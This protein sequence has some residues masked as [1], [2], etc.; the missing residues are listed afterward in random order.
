[1]SDEER[2]N[3]P[4]DEFPRFHSVSFA[5]EPKETSY[6]SI[7]NNTYEDEDDER[8]YLYARQSRRMRSRPRM[9]SVFHMVD[10]KFAGGI[11]NRANYMTRCF[12]TAWEINA[13]DIPSLKLLLWNG[14]SSQS[15][16]WQAVIGLILQWLLPLLPII[17]LPNYMHNL[18]IF[19][20][21]A[22]VLF[23]FEF[24]TLVW[25]SYV[26]FVLERN[27]KNWRRAWFTFEVPRGTI[28][29]VDSGESHEL[30][31]FH[32]S[33]NIRFIKTTFSTISRLHTISGHQQGILEE[34]MKS[35]G[36]E[37]C[38]VILYTEDFIICYSR[39]PKY[40]TLGLCVLQFA[41]V[42]L[43]IGMITTTW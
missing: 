31:L 13:A 35:R 23:V 37:T 15:P 38:E 19:L 39:W 11:V 42:I 18:D 7:K 8:E 1:M 2:K 9:T 29:L 36:L 22:W 10:S 20:E 43:L 32:F 21:L 17:L 25:H 41:S 34:D 33:A 24:L 6:T 28:G 12:R 5:E 27:K 14:E 4:F 26:M 40:M 30:T 3:L 16:S